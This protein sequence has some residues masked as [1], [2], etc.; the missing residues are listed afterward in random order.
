MQPKTYSKDVHAISKDAVN[1]HAIYAIEKL[2]EHGFTAYLVGG[3]VRDLASGREPK[4]FDIS[5]SARPGQIKKVFGRRCLLIGR[6]FRLAHLRFERQV[7][8]TATFRSGD[9][10]STLIVRDNR[11]GTP[12]EDAQRR[13]F[14]INGLFYDPTTETIIDYVDGWADI[15]DKILRT[16][17]DPKVRFQQDP[18]RMIRLL[19]FQARLDFCIED[20]ALRALKKHKKEIL[21]SAPARV[22]EEI[23]RMLES[24]YAE[25]FFSKMQK[26]GLLDLI[27]PKL[28]ANLSLTK[29]IHAFLSLADQINKQETRP[30][31]RGVLL[32][33][34]FFPLLEDSVMHAQTH[35]DKPLHLG[36]I[37]ALSQ[38]LLRQSFTPFFVRFPKKL[39]VE[40]QQILWNQYRLTQKKRY[41]LSRLMRDETI[42]DSIRFLKLRSLLDPSL[43]KT[44][45]RFCAALKKQKNG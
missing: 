32:S 8:E 44:Y 26:F 45:T 18:V 7:I 19:R 2:N 39:K 4:D 43:F 36:E 20:K 12:Q 31:S 25:P 15:H 35:E 37:F 42:K 17:G 1:A 24:G 14:T 27:L 6:R 9:D 28:D 30:I 33:G 16:I 11:W 23:L 34:L 3:S 38:K 13:D 21:K 22:L 29:R 40:T 10:D 41:P 5:T